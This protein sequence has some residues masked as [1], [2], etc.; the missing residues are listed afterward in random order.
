MKD[1]VF[2][3]FLRLIFLCFIVIS[4]TGCSVKK[5]VPVQISDIS[6]AKD[7][8]GTVYATVNV[9]GYGSMKFM[10]MNKYA[11]DA[12][13]I[14]TEAAKEGFFNEKSIYMV[15]K[16]FC[17]IAGSTEDREFNG[18]Q[19]IA[20]I[21]EGTDNSSCYPVKGAL[22]F[23]EALGQAGYSASNFTVIQGGSEFI[24]GLEELLKYKK[25]TLAEYFKQ[26][27]G[28]EISEDD[29]KIFRKY[30]G[31]PWLYGHCIVFGQLTEGEEVLDAICNCEV[32][33][34]SGFVPIEDIVIENITIETK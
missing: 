13:N 20:R 33:D 11:P 5:Q 4:V 15:I 32:T 22:C 26:A 25:V 1:Y 18:K 28:N 27:Y 31:A 34:D 10:L 17:F 14:F 2:M 30:G 12:V 21:G 3:H 29:L 19:L 8:T 23:T 16:D 24:A 7:A 9:R 6:D